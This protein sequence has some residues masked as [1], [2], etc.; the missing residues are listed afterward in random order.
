MN[1]TVVRL[2]RVPLTI[3]M[4]W[5][6]LAVAVPPLMARYSTYVTRPGFDCARTAI[7]FARTQ[8]L[9]AGACQSLS[10]LYGQPFPALFFASAFRTPPPLLAA[11]VLA[12]LIGTLLAFA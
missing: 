1:P 2:L 5:A 7:Q 3:A 12:L 4:I 11:P 8:G 10:D 9:P 6:V